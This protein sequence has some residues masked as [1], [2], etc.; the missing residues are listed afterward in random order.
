MTMIEA[1]NRFLRTRSNPFGKIGPGGPPPAAM[2][3][4]G[5]SVGGDGGGG[6]GS[7]DGSGAVMVAAAVAVVRRWS[8]MVD[9]IVEKGIFGVEELEN[10]VECFLELNSEEHHK[11]NTRSSSIGIPIRL[12][13]ASRTPTYNSRHNTSFNLENIYT[14]FVDQWEA[15]DR[16]IANAW[17]KNANNLKNKK[18]SMLIGHHEVNRRKQQKQ[19]EISARERAEKRS[20]M[21]KRLKELETVDRDNVDHVLDIQEIMHCY[22]L[23]TCPAYCEMVEKFFSEMYSE[24]F[25]PRRKSI[26]V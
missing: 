23:L 4:G 15:A 5:G 19:E 25:N 16:I 7:G 12:R 1:G 22:S 2:S 6:G 8:S 26:R 11:L 20:L 3:G 18:P 24:V 14:E 17:E 13:K 9:M 10:L 21:T